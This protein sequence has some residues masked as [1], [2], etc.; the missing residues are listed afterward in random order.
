MR[1]LIFL[2]IAVFT[3]SVAG[4]QTT[5]PKIVTPPPI[6]PCTIKL[7]NAPT[8][9]GLRLDMTKL[10]VQKEYPLMKISADSVTSSGMI[11]GYQI[12]NPEYQSNVE[13]ITVAFKNNKV[14]SVLV[15]YNE[16]VK[17][18]SPEEFAQKISESL[19]LPK[20]VQRKAA[21]SVYYSVNCG[22]FGVR[23]RINGDKQATLFLT[24]DPEELWETT[25]QKKDAFK[26]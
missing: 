15:T 7:T 18:D 5:P 9:R 2:L 23:T 14:F 17:W 25:Q 21:N 11:M 20:P 19:K 26:P 1:F 10:D 3:I 16:L 22:E 6:E 13:R 24:R 12:G 8:V 4:Q